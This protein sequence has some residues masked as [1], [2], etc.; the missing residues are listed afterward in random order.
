MWTSQILVLIQRS[1]QYHCCQSQEEVSPTLRL[2]D[3]ED[4]VIMVNDTHHLV[5]RINQLLMDN[6]STIKKLELVT[7]KISPDVPSLS[8]KT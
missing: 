1:R 7:Q 5:L 8:W 6:D 3:S 2:P 4:E